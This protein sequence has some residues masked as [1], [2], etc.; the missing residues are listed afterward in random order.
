MIAESQ[1]HSTKKKKG[2]KKIIDNIN[3]K[4]KNE[5]DIFFT[6]ITIKPRSASITH[7]DKIKL[8]EKQQNYIDTLNKVKIYYY[9]YIFKN[10]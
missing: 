3:C 1:L 10:I 2:G 7:D 6:K 8:V 9:I 4:N 5:T